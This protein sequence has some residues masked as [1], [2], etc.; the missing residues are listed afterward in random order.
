[1][2]IIISSLDANGMKVTGASQADINSAKLF[3]AKSLNVTPL[4]LELILDN[5]VY[6]LNVTSSPSYDK[7]SF[8]AYGLSAPYSIPL[9][10]LNYIIKAGQG[11][12]KVQLQKI[13]SL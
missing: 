11:Q 10:K 5:F 6:S 7:A 4:R 9:I 8:Y 13:Q 3:I 12:M 2:N 1:M